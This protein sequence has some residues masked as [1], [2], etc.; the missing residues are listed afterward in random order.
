MTD[1]IEF[2]LGVSPQFLFM[3]LLHIPLRENRI[4]ELEEQKTK[5]LEKLA[6]LSAEND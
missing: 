6:E 4:R 3:S 1:I 5:L 2:L